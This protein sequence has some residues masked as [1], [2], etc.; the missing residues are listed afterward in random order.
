MYKRQVVIITQ[1]HKPALR[2][3]SY[4][5]ASRPTSVQAITVAVD[6]DAAEAL[7]REWD[8]MGLPVPLTILDS[9][10]RELVRPVMNHIADI[11]R[12]RPDDLIDVYIPQY[13]VGRRWENILHNQTV[14][15]LK[16]RL[17]IVP[18]VVVSIVPWRLRSFTRNQ[19]VLIRRVGDIDHDVIGREQR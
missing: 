18:N 3:L 10:Y 2:A 16:S 19:D 6:K 17:L 4:A 15:R 1:I 13:I 11:R 5:R 7:Q 8:E 9:P 14:L 12:H